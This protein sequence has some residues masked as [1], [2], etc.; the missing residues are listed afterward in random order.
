MTCS[1][2]RSGKVLIVYAFI[3]EPGKAPNLTN[4]VQNNATSIKVQWLPL[5]KK[6]EH[7]I[8]SSYFIVY[9]H[10]NDT[11]TANKTYYVDTPSGP[12]PEESEKDSEEHGETNKPTPSP[13]LGK[14][15]EENIVGLN[16]YQ[17]YCFKVAARNQKGLSNYSVEKCERTN[18]T[19]KKQLA[20]HIQNLFVKPFFG[21][22]PYL[23]EIINTGHFIFSGSAI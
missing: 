21:F 10:E 3:L 19:S 23:P 11:T 8:I 20:L 14:V 4:V 17:I 15:L 16:P 9:R 18:E 22:V 5:E 2:E 6:Y 7:G 12:K 1:I 13:P